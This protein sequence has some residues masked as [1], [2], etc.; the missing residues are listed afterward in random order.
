MQKN[1]PTEYEQL[2]DLFD[3]HKLG[4]APKLSVI[5]KRALYNSWLLKGRKLEKKVGEKLFPKTWDY[6]TM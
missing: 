4:A 3:K 1:Y 2:L 5:E 6:I